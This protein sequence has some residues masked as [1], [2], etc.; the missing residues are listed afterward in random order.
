MADTKGRFWLCQSCGK[1]VPARQTECRCGFSRADE[2]EVAFESVL[3]PAGGTSPAWFA[4]GPA[5]LIVMSVATLGLYQIYW[6]YQQWRRVRD[7]GEDVWPVPRS[8]FGVI[9][10]YPLFQRMLRASPDDA[11][12]G[13]PGVLA[14]AYGLLCVASNLPMP[15]G[16]VAFLSV[17]PLAAV[18]RVASAAAERDFPADDPNRRLTAANWAGVA[19]GG[20]LL[21]LVFYGAFV[22]DRPTS[23]AFLSRVAAQLNQAPKVEK[24]GALLD[25]VV[26]HEGTLVYHYTVRDE[27]RTRV[28]EMKPHLKDVVR[29][30]LCRDRLLKTGVTVRFVYTDS[31][32][33][34]LASVAVAPDD[35]R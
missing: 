33:R 25:K 17:L 34:E 1:H 10:S 13:G 27:V 12:A 4:V 3:T 23:V 28:E 14:V 32:G 2:P 5:K 35:C 29:P 6:F 31:T 19:V 26:A 18:Q 20:V 22:R 8:I 21:G 24:N 9:F 15:F 16:F 7:G 11:P 30:S